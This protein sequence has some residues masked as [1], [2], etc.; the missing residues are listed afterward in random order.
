MLFNCLNYIN[1][2]TE[3]ELEIFSLVSK[4]LSK[5]ARHI[6]H[7]ERLIAFFDV[8]KKKAQVLLESIMIDS[9]FW[10]DGEIAVVLQKY[11]DAK[12][13]NEGR[14]LI[15][16]LSRAGIIDLAQRSAFKKIL[17]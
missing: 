1:T 8:D 14:E 6:K 3:K 11:K 17:E 10:K 16:A 12:L 2:Y 4:Q 15:T 9:H 5:H 7:P 13:I